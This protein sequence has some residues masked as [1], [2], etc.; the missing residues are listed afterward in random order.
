MIYLDNH[1]TTKPLR[2]CLEQQETICRE[3]WGSID[4]PHVLGQSLYE[5]VDSALLGIFRAAGAFDYNFFSLS[6][7][8]MQAVREVYL[9]HYLNH[10]RDTGKT[11]FLTT[12]VEEA[13]ILLSLNQMERL[14]CSVKTIPIDAAGRVIVESLSAAIRPRVSLL[15]LSWVCGLTG[16]VQPMQEIAELCKKKEIFLHI[17]ASHAIGKI[18]VSLQDIECAFFTFDGTK[19]HAPAGTTGILSRQK[20]LPTGAV[21]LASLRSLQIAYEAAIEQTDYATTEIARLRA[22]WETNLQKALPDIQVLFQ[23]VERAPHI[24]VIAFVGVH[25]E[26]LLFLL[27]Q[28]GLCASIGGGQM[29]KLATFLNACGYS[30]EISDS[31]ISFAFS[32]DTTDADI[33]AA[34]AVVVTAV[35]HLRSLGMHL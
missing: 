23:E 19:F 18:G 35:L 26:A 15:S 33:D 5:I 27:S 34:V 11:H 10:M 12:A 8:A 29:Q 9:A 22:L 32:Y 4:A 13:S 16:V 7:N 31:A 3:A 20:L 6:A 2:K 21:S 24:S 28:A 25:A 30:T 17:D 1:T 14:G